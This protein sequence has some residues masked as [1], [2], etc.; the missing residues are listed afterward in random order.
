MEASVLMHLPPV[1]LRLQEAAVNP[2]RALLGRVQ[3]FSK[4]L[5]ARTFAQVDAARVDPS[6]PAC[7]AGF[8]ADFV[9]KAKRKAIEDHVVDYALLGLDRNQLDRVRVVGTGHTHAQSQ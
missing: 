3:H 7:K 8:G 4:D 6:H 1:V 5:L 2:P 9:S